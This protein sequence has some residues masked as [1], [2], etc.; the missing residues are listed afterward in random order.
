[1]LR[2]G[3]RALPPS[4][5]SERLALWWGFKFRPAPRV[6]KLRSDALVYV[7]PTDY[8]QLLIYYIGTFEPYCLQYLRSCA[9]NGAT[10]VDVGANIGFYTLE[11]AVAVGSTGRV[12]SIEPAPSNAGAL[13]RNVELNHL[14]NVDLIEVAAGDCNGSATLTLASGDN[15]GMFTLAPSD[16][17]K[18]YSVEV[19]RIDDLLEDRGI[20]S[21]DLIKMD[22]E[23]SEYQA[24]RGAVNTL[25]TCRP[26]VLIELNDEALRNL[27]SSANEVL[28]LLASLGYRGWI[29]GRSDLR[30]IKPLQS[31]REECECLFVHRDNISLIQGLRLP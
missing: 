29:V 11:S 8:L 22:V 20:T 17:G 4:A 9:G 1:M 24:L 27:Q 15:L 2:A 14:T 12:I 13:R 7:D 21:I 30:P 23:G 3:L 5:W 16:S 28:E 25:R 26:A 18:S 19:R 6:V 31:V 10:I